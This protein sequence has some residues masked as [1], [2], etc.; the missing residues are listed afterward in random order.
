[1]IKRSWFRLGI[2][3]VVLAIGSVVAA[4]LAI[5]P[6]ARWAMIANAIGCA[7]LAAW[8]LRKDDDNAAE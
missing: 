7:G 8:A 1:M 2:A 3:H 6:Q 5:D 4:C